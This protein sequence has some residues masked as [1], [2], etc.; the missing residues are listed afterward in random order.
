MTNRDT[1]IVATVRSR[2]EQRL[3]EDRFELWFGPAVRFEW[4]GGS[5]CIVA[6]CTFRVDRL[7]ARL[8]SEVLAVLQ[9][10]GHDDAVVQ[11]RVD[12]ALAS[13]S[14]DE[15]ERNTPNVRRSNPAVSSVRRTNGSPVVDRPAE[16][17]GVELRPATSLTTETSRRPVS[18]GSNSARKFADIRRF[19]R[20]CSN[21]IAA[22]AAD[23]V[24]GQPGQLNP[25]FIHGP[26]GTGKTHLLEGIWREVRRRGGRRIIYLSSEQFTTYF[27]QA[28]RGGGLPSFRQKYRAVD[29]FILDDVQFFAGKQ[30]T[31]TE[32]LHTMDALLKESRQLV[33]ASDRPPV[34]LHQ[35]GS[36]LQARIAGGLVCS[37]QP[38]DID[39]RRVLLTRMANERSIPVSEEILD[40]VAERI[41]GD[42]RQLGGVMNRL[43]ATSQALRKAVTIQ[44]AEEVVAELCPESGGVIKLND[45][46][47]VVCDEFGIVPEQL[48]SK[49]R[50]RDVSHPRMLAMWLARKHTH[51]ALTE[52]GEF[53]GKRSHSTV[54]SAQNKVEGWVSKG[55]LLK[56]AQQRMDVRSLLSR[57][58][59]SLRA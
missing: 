15:T 48:C 13:H 43:W 42:A 1:E 19:E 33:L 38:L 8:Q 49:S 26:T 36:E 44:M 5:L 10:L 24:I 58:E 57:L 14:V 12:S 34:E 31:I 9:Q 4:N 55:E 21:Q 25:L 37:I 59:R 46:Q 35:L 32:L 28:L 16:K 45:I 3:G 54:V 27:L 2:L 53:F 29:L 41:P 11:F 23:M 7:R 20:G 40:L 47:R 18:W 30:A 22:S 6:D 50:S 51:A 52:I 56:L 17:G 39:V